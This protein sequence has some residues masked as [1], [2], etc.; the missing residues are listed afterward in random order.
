M[1]LCEFCKS[2]L[3][4]DKHVHAEVFG[5]VTGISF[6]SGECANAWLSNKEAE[7]LVDLETTL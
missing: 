4:G 5:Y 7:L 1:R 3:Y 6:C 2:K